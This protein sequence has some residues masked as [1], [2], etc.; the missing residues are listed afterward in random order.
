MRWFRIRSVSH[1]HARP[2]T[3]RGRSMLLVAATGLTLAAGVAHAQCGSVFS[4]IDFG[5]NPGLS[6]NGSAAIVGTELRLTPAGEGTAGTAWS[7]D[8]VRI[9]DGFRTEF[10]FVIRNGSADGFAFVIQNES[11]SVVGGGGSGIGYDGIRPGLAVEFDTFSFPD[12]F[13]Q[14]HVSVHLSGNDPLSSGDETSIAHAVLT[15][16]IADGEPHTVVI[17]YAFGE[18][19]VRL[20]GVPVLVTSV[21]LS[22]LDEFDPPLTQCAWVGFAAGSGAATA[23]QVITAWSFTDWS[24]STE[25]GPL[26]LTA[27]EASD[28]SPTTGDRVVL[29]AGVAGTG[30]RTYRWRRE[31]IAL[32]DD[33]RRLGTGTEVMVIDPFIPAD[34]GSYQFSTEN[35]CGGFGVGNLT[36]EIEC[37]GDLN[38]DSFVDNSDFSFFVEAYN[39]L[40]VPDADRR[41]DWN[42]DRLVDNSDF[43]LFVGYYN[44]L[45]CPG[46]GR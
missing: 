30:P 46:T 36:L 24:D 23:D 13:A 8:P 14:P 21:S 1:A 29:T 3:Q 6:L 27:F 12:E 11:D 44:E 31:E 19:S 33:A 22:A 32:S 37:P 34:A 5:S 10:T 26:T 25:C 35:S 7:L 45:L 42:G 16:S 2:G 39:Q 18:L 40:I 28:S 38:L 17:E 4:I 43:V 9:A 41:C 20:D 15:G